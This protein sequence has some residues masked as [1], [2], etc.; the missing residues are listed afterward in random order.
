MDTAVLGLGLIGGSVLRALA[1]AG[2][3]VSG[4]DADP[5]TRTLARA[6]ASGAPAA[7]RWQ[8]DDTVGDAVA[9]AALVLVAVPLPALP[10]VLDEIVTSGYHG[11]VTDVTSVKGAVRDVV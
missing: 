6:A 8:V 7:A 11:I 1:G 4:Y 10:T 3:R 5:A 9:G 2:H